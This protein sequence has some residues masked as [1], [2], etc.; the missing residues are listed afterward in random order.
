[1]PLFLIHPAGGISWGY[2][3][4]ARL[5]APARRVW[6]VQHPGLDPQTA[7]PENL[8]ALARE[9]MHHILPQV[10]EGPVHLAGWSVGGIIAQAMA[11]ELAAAGREAGLVAVLDSYPADAWRDEPDPDP[12]AALRALLAIAGHDPNAHLDLDTREKVVAFLR[13]TG[14]TLGALPGPV[15]DGIVR[16]VTDTN[17]LVRGHRHRPMQGRLTHIRAASDHAGTGL[18]A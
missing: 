17:R 8:D 14:T 15:L 10:P 11:V 9:Y 2:R 7:L 16:L 1:A 5:I 13:A 4:L 18:E 12:V 3:H 6:G